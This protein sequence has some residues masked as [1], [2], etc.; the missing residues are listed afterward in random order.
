M[1]YDLP[2]SVEVHGTVYEIRSDYRSILDICMALE[3]P[4]LGSQEKSFVLLDIFYSDFAD[5]P[6]E[7]YQEAVQKCIWFINCGEEG[8]ARKSIKL[9]DWGQG[10]QTDR[11][12]SQPDLRTGS[13]SREIPA[14]VVL[15]L[16][17]LRNWGMSIRTGDPD[18][19]EKG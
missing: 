17:L 9:V 6:E 10:L 16:C 1:I 18:P 11:R 5:M 13:K 8:E 14:L 15:H 12:P 3:D 19:G 7:H 4:E 2:T